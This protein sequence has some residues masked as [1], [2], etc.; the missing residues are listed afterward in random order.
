MVL[1]SR[2]GRRTSCRRARANGVDRPEAVTGESS[3]VRN[4]APEVVGAHEGIGMRAGEAVRH[5]AGDRADRAGGGMALEVAAAASQSRSAGAL[6]AATD[7]EVTR[8]GNGLMREDAG[9]EE[10]SPAI[11]W[12][13]GGKKKRE[14]LSSTPWRAQAD[15]TR[16][17][18]SQPALGVVWSCISFQILKRKESNLKGQIINW[19]GKVG[20]KRNPNVMEGK[21]YSPQ[22]MWGKK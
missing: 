10:L 7:K 2:R 20:Q 6:R 1:C 9:S 12:R 21:S 4:G 19:Q 3:R 17:D 5:G 16:S 15:Q 8:H 11:L 18:S 13:P 14:G 22:V